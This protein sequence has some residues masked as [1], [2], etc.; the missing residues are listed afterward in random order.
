MTRTALE[1]RRPR[2]A[3]VASPRAAIPA[4][5][6]GGSVEQV[7]G[8]AAALARRGYQVT[9]IGAGLP[10]TPGAGTSYQ[11]IDTWLDE[12]LTDPVLAEALHGIAVER[13]LRRLEVD[14]VHEH[15][16]AGLLNAV[17]GP[18]GG[19]GDVPQVVTVYGPADGP[20]AVP[21]HKLT[22]GRAA[23][24][25]VSEHQRAQ[26]PSLPWLGVVHPGI[27]VT[28]YPFREEKDGPCVFVGALAPGRGADLAIVAAHA[29]GR[30]ITVAGTLPHPGMETYVRW[31]LRPLLRPG[32]ELIQVTDHAKRI[33]LLAHA[34]CLVAPFGPDVPFSLAIVEA[35]A[36][37]TPVVALRGGVGEEL[38]EHG[39]SGIL[40]PTP[41]E[42]AAGIA[43]AERLDPA[44]CRHHAATHFDTTQ[45]A[46]GYDR[47]YAQ[48]LAARH[49]QRPAA[50]PDPHPHRAPVAA[51]GRSGP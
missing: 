45:M 46:A 2:V 36:C 42:L 25:A 20:D 19:R 24:V 39:A 38:V 34:R 32:D 11:A 5:A 33:G 13:L 31:R 16:V 51:G 12:D 17:S 49:P 41:A 7:T 15:T 35:L 14:L 9:V 48:A 44:G 30:S 21:A 1:L 29:A 50:P 8:L 27:L 37:G 18:A 28:E 22:G 26:A 23:L 47:L 40:C 43:A 6:Y 10:V 4:G 3:L